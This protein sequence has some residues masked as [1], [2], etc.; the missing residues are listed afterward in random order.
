MCCDQMKWG[1]C[2]HFISS[3]NV[4]HRCEIWIQG[5]NWT[6]SWFDKTARTSFGRIDVV[7][8]RVASCESRAE[9]V[10]YIRETDRRMAW[11]ASLHR[12]KSFPDAPNQ[13]QTVDYRS[14]PPTVH[15]AVPWSVGEIDCLENKVEAAVLLNYQRHS[16]QLLES[17]NMKLQKCYCSR[18]KWTEN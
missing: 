8:A 15:L 4:K 13:R 12:W 1:F 9:I 17:E 2:H 7:L 10:C 6:T 11:K 5:C 18:C 3:S 16:I 14:V